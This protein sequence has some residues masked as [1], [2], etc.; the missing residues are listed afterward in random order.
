[1]FWRPL[2][3]ALL[4][5]SVILLL[6]GCAS[7][8]ASPDGG[9]HHA[10]HEGHEK[11]MEHG[12]HEGHAAHGGGEEMLICPV[13]GEVIE[14]ESAFVHDYKGKEI[15]FCCKKCVGAFEKDPEKYLP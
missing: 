7:D 8:G 2:G 5:V 1:M 14:E 13:S 6:G 12:G 15:T 3:V 11:P 4:S 10:S 9:D